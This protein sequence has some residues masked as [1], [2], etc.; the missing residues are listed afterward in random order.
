[1]ALAVSRGSETHIRPGAGSKLACF[2][3]MPHSSHAIRNR[4][5]DKRL[6]R[7][8]MRGY[9]SVR[10]KNCIFVWPML[11]SYAWIEVRSDAQRK[12]GLPGSLCFSKPA[13]VSAYAL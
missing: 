6:W 4:K 5:E 13:S 9:N 11:A 7:S 1:M 8:G 12:A 2:L 10:D 3:T